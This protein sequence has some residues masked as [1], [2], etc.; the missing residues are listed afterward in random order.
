[1]EESSPR[2]TR[3]ER[4][5]AS[6][7]CDALQGSLSCNHC[8]RFRAKLSSAPLIAALPSLIADPFSSTGVDFVGSLHYKLQRSSPKKACTHAIHLTLCTDMIVGR[9][10]RALKEFVAR[11]APPPPSSTSR[12]SDNVILTKGWLE[13]LQGDEDLNNYLESSGSLTSPEHHR[14]KEF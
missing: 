7:D 13:T 6:L 14:G 11:R 9:F 4:N 8:K 3:C 10:K 1:M 12:V 5:S 2:E